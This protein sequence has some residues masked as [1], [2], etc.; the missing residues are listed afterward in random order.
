MILRLPASRRLRALSGFGIALVLSWSTAYSQSER[1]ACR[2][3]DKLIGRIQL[4]TADSAG[5]WWHLTRSG[6]EAA[7]IVG[8]AAQLATMQVWFGVGFNTLSE[9]VA[10]LVDQVRPVDVNGNGFVCAYSL[11]GTRTSLG[12]P[13]FAHYLFGVQDDRQ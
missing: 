12:D 13:N 8:D 7:G 5:T 6:M 1:H 10:H 11:R 2:P 3:D 9:A 4:S